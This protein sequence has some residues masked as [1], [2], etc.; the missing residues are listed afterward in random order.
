MCEALKGTMQEREQKEPNTFLQW[1]QFFG[2]KYRL[3]SFKEEPQKEKL[4]LPFIFFGKNKF[5]FNSC[6]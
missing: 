1:I 6:W 5:L 2:V 3:M 4:S